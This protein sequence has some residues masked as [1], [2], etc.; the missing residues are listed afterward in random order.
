[1]LPALLLVGMFPFEELV[2]VVF[3]ELDSGTSHLGI[4]LDVVVF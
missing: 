2:M 3:L 4:E 1:L